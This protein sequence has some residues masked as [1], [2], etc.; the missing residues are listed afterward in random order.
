MVAAGV[1]AVELTFSVLL[2]AANHPKD[3]RYDAHTAHFLQNSEAT[4]T[5]NRATAN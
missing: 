1:G 2:I 5:N 3:G 4:S